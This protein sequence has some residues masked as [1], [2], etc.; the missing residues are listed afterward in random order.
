MP[1]H[2][3]RTV[4]TSELTLDTSSKHDKASKLSADV[5]K[6]WLINCKTIWTSSRFISKLI[7][8]IDMRY[9]AKKDHI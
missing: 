7:K 3:F 1:P 8:H 5:S 6:C 4:S 9:E 2:F